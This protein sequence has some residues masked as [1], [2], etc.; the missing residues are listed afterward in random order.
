M[1]V[2]VPP[3]AQ[4]QVHPASCRVHLF[5]VK[6]GWDLKTGVMP[7]HCEADEV[8]SRVLSARRLYS[9]EHT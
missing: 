9:N 1:R 3:P 7:R 6:R 2:Q 5:L 8:G 4:E